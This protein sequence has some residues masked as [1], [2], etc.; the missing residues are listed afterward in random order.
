MY[1]Y[2]VNRVLCHCIVNE[3]QLDYKL[4]RLRC[5]TENIWGKIIIITTTTTTIIIIVI[6]HIRIVITK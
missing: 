4:L 2:S 1:F 5:R 6:I 3:N